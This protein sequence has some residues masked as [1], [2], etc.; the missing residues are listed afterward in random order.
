MRLRKQDKG[1]SARKS[2]PAYLKSNFKIGDRVRV[3]EIPEDTKDPKVDLKSA[4][5]REMRTAELFR[6]CLGCEFT[7]RGF[8]QYGHVELEVGDDSS[9]RK[10]FGRFNTIWIEPEFL[11]PIGTQRLKAHSGRSTKRL[12][13]LVNIA[14]NQ[15]VPPRAG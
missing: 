13:G 1:G 4:E 7:V 5:A 12:A 11:E 10:K 3:I 2:S 15:Q 14:C 9:V 6:F 8:G